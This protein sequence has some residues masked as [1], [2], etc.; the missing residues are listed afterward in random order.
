MFWAMLMSDV[1]RKKKGPEWCRKN[2]IGPMREIADNPP[3]DLEFATR[4]PS[5]AQTLAETSAS[6]ALHCRKCGQ[7][8]LGRP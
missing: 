1:M 7:C 4:G 8:K 3:A 6:L 2:L 5:V